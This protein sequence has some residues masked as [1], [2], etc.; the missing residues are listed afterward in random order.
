[1]ADIPKL[2]RRGN[3]FE[4]VVQ[5]RARLLRAGELGNSAASTV[6]TLERSFAAVAD[7]GLDALLVPVSWELCEPTE[8]AFDFTLVDAALAFARRHGLLLV[9]LWFGSYKNSM[10][11]YVPGWVK[12]DCQRFPRAHLAD[13]TPIE[14]LSA[15]AEENVATDARAFAALLTHLARVDAKAGTVPLIQVENEVGML[16][17]AREHGRA[18]DAAFH[19]AV[20]PDLLATLATAP[21]PATL[22]ALWARHGR[23]TSGTWAEVFGTDP[24]GEEVFTA[25]HL[26]RYTDRVAAAGK[27]AYPLPCF[28]NAALN[29][30]GRAP[31]EYPAGGPLPHLFPVWQAAA[32]HLDILAPDIYFP[33][34]VRCLAPYAALDQPLFVP[35]TRW[36][37]DAAATAFY[38]FG[39]ARALGFSPFAIETPNP[40]RDAFR[41][42]YELLGTLE[43]VLLTGHAAGVVG[44]VLL[45]DESPR[46]T[47]TVGAHSLAVAHDLTWGFAA[48]DPTVKPW[49]RAGALVIALD[50]ETLLVAG[51]GVI[52]TFPPRPDGTHLGLASVEEGRWG[53][54]GWLRQRHL[55]GD[56]THQGRHVRIPHGVI[57]LQRVV[58][59]EYR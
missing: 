2:V 31:G 36:D 25:Y 49:Q 15:F 59:Y 10:S 33:D 13:G 16:E 47:L 34:F 23:R 4:L 3:T 53:P 48:A 45:D 44:A 40:G 32:P 20:P 55:N 17:A 21:L 38:G 57:G 1:M 46:A 37:A 30:A 28:V 29:R 24:T 12:R 26:A 9:P 43:Q 11:T 6:E 51:T 35:E 22:E 27:A 14:I 39:Q 5:G 18:A 42:A 56:E 54:Q 50:S 58:T 19:A 41:Q 52:V 8:G 7:L